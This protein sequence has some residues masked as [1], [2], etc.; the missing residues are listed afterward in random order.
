MRPDAHFDKPGPSPFMDMAPAP[1]FADAADNNVGGVVVSAAVIQRLGI[2]TALPVRRNVRPSLRVPA[3]VD[4][5]IERL[6]VRAVG[7]PVI[8]G[9]VIAE[10]YS[11]ELMQAQEELLLSADTAGLGAERLHRFSIADSGIQAI[12]HA[13]KASRRL[14][15]RAPVSGIVTELGRAKDRSCH[16]KP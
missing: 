3:R 10:I 13:G 1:K 15:L 5:G 12:R 2:R 7:Q 11:P 6:S 9:S 4:G 14:P 8:A 16:R